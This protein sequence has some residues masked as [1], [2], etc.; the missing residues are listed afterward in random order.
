MILVGDIGGTKTNIAIF[1]SNERG[2]SMV[3]AQQSCASAEYES[4]EAILE[5]FLTEHDLTVTRACFGVAGPVLK[6]CVE[7]PNLSWT[8]CESTLIKTLGVK[9]VKLIND[10]EATARGIEA[11]G[12]AQLRTLNDGDAVRGGDAALIAAGTGLGM[13]GIHVHQGKRLPLASEGGHA[14]FAP[15]TE[16]EIELLR[17]LIKRY[18]QHVSYERVLSGTGLF[19]IYTFLRD[20]NFAAEPDWLAASTKADHK[21]AAIAAIAAAALEQ[22]SELAVKAL[23]MFVSIYGAA[24]GNLAL[25]MKATGGVFIGGG[26]APKIIRKLADGTFM[27]AFASKGRFSSFLEA[28]P[29]RVILDDKTALYGAARCALKEA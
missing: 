21:P 16:I 24:A 29:V 28:I 9:N 27:R 7:T 8:V 10:L 17:Y 6:G 3:V 12:A 13:V 19:D 18:D 5:E 23:D 14:D 2:V 4:L 11:L 15:R 22:Q 26:I 1:K 25:T 20:E